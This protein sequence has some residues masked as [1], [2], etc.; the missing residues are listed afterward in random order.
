MAS[1]L[2]CF[3]SGLICLDPNANEVD[4]F[5]TY[6]S[7]KIPHSADWKL[8]AGL[9]HFYLDVHSPQWTLSS[10]A[11]NEST[12]QISNTLQ[13]IYK[14]QGTMMFIMYDDE[15]PDS[16]LTKGGGHTKG[17]VAFDE[18][19]GFWMIHSVPKFP[20]P[21]SE[22]YS[23]PHSGIDYGQTFLCVSLP[24]EELGVV[25]KQLL[26]NQPNIYDYNVP[27]MFLESFSI[28]NDLIDGKRPDGPP[29]S[30]VQK[31]TS[32]DKQIFLSFAKAN[33]FHA[34]LYDA[35]VAP[36]LK[37]DL[38]VE[39]WLRERGT[40]L[41][42]NCSTDYHVLKVDKIQLPDGVV[43]N[44]TKDH[45]KWAVTM[46]EEHSQAETWAKGQNVMHM[47]VSETDDT[48]WAC[49][50]DINRMD[51]QFHRGGGTLCIQHSGVWKA[52]MGAVADYVKCP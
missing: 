44:E 2:C 28:L 17:V 33:Y 40:P 14:P 24:Y 21:Q 50:G 51:S 43:F 18:T 42:S 27:D 1:T 41:P 6:K 10:K 47:V 36:T 20:P 5:S 34:D 11:V 13:Q 38:L 37:K 8:H 32:I 4:W 23:W 16:L 3:N 45:A 30:S 29:W 15:R 48:N 26:F 39:T 9:A 46:P 25:A 49:V 22:G 12:Q 7:P 31:L 52:F 19:S 35:L